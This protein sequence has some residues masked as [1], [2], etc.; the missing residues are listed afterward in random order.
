[1]KHKVTFTIKILLGGKVINAT[2]ST[3][4]NQRKVKVLYNMSIIDDNMRWYD[5]PLHIW[6][7]WPKSKEEDNAFSKDWPNCY[8]LSK[9][10]MLEKSIILQKEGHN[11]YEINRKDFRLNRKGQIICKTTGKVVAEMIK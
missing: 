9:E 6:G 5:E 4:V 8:S 3:G 1:M 2:T 11:Q 10:E 7:I